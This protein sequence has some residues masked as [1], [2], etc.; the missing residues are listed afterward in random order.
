MSPVRDLR[1]INVV[2]AVVRY[3]VR[4]QFET[5]FGRGSTPA[6]V[7]AVRAVGW[8]GVLLRQV[9]VIAVRVVICPSAG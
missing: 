9:P 1:V 7:G 3:T 6:T 8:S 4:T 2:D 5:V